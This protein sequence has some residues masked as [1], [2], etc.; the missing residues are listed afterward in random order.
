MADRYSEEFWRRLSGNPVSTTFS[1]NGRSD[2]PE[3]YSEF[4]RDFRG[5]RRSEASF[6]WD[7]I[8]LRSRREWFFPENMPGLLVFRQTIEPSSSCDFHLTSTMEEPDGVEWSAADFLEQENN[9]CGFLLK[10]R[11]GQR[12][13][14]CE[15]T[16]IFS[17]SIRVN[18]TRERCTHHYEINAF[19][20]CPVKLEKFVSFRTEGEDPD[21]IGTAFRECREASRRGFD[22]LK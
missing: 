21:Y 6:C 12:A 18:E 9:A 8:A 1:M 16:Q 5:V 17:V 4:S 3:A 14:L 10:N 20:E 13:I 2:S 15:T 22:M 11:D 7:N 19:E